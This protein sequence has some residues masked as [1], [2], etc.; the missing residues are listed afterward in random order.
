MRFLQRKFI[1]IL[2]FAASISGHSLH[3]SSGETPSRGKDVLFILRGPLD[4]AIVTT[5]P[6][7]DNN[8][9]MMRLPDRNA[10]KLQA[11]RPKRGA[12]V[13]QRTLART[14]IIKISINDQLKARNSSSRIVFKPKIITG[15]VRMPRVKFSS[16]EPVVELR[17]E[18]P[19]IDFTAKSLKDGGF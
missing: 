7:N 13:T 12:I 1:G 5:A 16:L 6:L 9:Q 19:S 2:L 10:K 8:V 17:E 4:P 3:A 14:K 15:E 11:H 18:L